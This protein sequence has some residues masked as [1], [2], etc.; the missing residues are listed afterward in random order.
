MF[1][2][3]RTMMV[4]QYSMS[5]SIKKLK[6]CGFDG[7]EMSFLDREFRF[8]PDMTEPFFAEHTLQVAYEQNMPIYSTSLHG[9]YVYDDAKYE[10]IKKA[11][12]ATPMYGT[13]LCIISNAKKTYNDQKDW[14]TL[15]ERT[16]RLLE[17][18]E[19]V[20]VTL[21]MEFE[22]GMI[23]GTTAEL[24]RLFEEMDSDHLMA[25]LDIGHVFLCDPDPMEAIRSLK[26]KI[27]HCHVE[28]MLRGV[29]RHMVPYQGD[30]DLKSYFETLKE[31]GFDGAA[32][33]DIY[34]GDYESLGR[35]SVTYLK[36]LSGRKDI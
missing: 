9:N 10:A 19:K 30:M 21:A 14:N 5:E 22:P 8:R 17:I 31:V 3:G 1:F 4:S 7:L 26:G 24:H 11:I 34:E 32:G 6:A 33:L 20:N 18:A 15:I 29:H 35:L 12:E 28:N 2:T 27:A 36:E 25:N 16:R 23:C 13:N